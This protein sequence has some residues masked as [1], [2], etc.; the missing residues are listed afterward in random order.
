MLAES[1]GLYVFVRLCEVGCVC[2][3]V[4]V[5]GVCMCD[6]P[7]PTGKSSL[8][9]VKGLVEMAFLKLRPFL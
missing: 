6:S 7:Q 3:C 5:C 2:V 9:E 1:Q 8:V 4:C